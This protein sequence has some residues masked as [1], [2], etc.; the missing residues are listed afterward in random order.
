LAAATL[1]ASVIAVLLGARGVVGV[2][3]VAIV[4]AAFATVGAVLGRPRWWSA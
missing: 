3:A 1:V 4:L 2:G